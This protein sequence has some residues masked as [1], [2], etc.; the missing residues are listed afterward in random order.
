MKNKSLLVVIFLLVVAV[1]VLG[2]YNQSLI[3]NKEQSLEN[4]ELLVKFESENIGTVTL[5]TIKS[6]G[7]ETFK[8]TLRS[9]GAPPEDHIYT[10][11]PIKNIL[12]FLDKDLLDK[13]KRMIVRALDGYTSVFYMEE[14]KDEK[15]V[16]LVYGQ[17]GKPLRN[18]K[19]GGNGPLMIVAAKDKYGQRWCKYVIEVDIE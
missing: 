17:D 19:E 11:V 1:A 3:T 18:R 6:L 14:V 4:P 13:G 7:E 5:E 10:G 12:N 15:N 2:Y 9:S 8:A 16:Y